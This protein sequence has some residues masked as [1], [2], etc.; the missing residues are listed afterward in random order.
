MPPKVNHS[1]AQLL[2][3]LLVTVRASCLLEQPNLQQLYESVAAGNLSHLP[4]EVSIQY[5]LIRSCE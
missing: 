2:L 4:K 1:A 5:G 3:S